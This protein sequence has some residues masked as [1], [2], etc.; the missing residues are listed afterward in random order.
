M[1]QTVLCETF[2]QR[3]DLDP[4]VELAESGQFAGLEELGLPADKRNDLSLEA[5]K[6]LVCACPMLKRVTSQMHANG[7]TMVPSLV[8][9]RHR[10]SEDFVDFVR[11][12]SEDFV[13][14]KTNLLLLRFRTSDSNWV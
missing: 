2:H 8:E 1:F 3:T 5:V 11:K 10:R 13:I 4:I 14:A 9:N 12:R 7:K 6:R